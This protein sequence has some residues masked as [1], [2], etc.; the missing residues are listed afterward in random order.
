LRFWDASAIVPLLVEEPAHP[1]VH[2][3]LADDTSM[4]VWWASPVECVSAL[5]RRNRE[6]SLEESALRLALERLRVLS[7]AWHEILPT[8]TV[9]SQAERMLRV[10]PLRAA[11]AL[12]LAA[13]LV[14]AEQQPSDL[15][16]LCLDDRLSAAAS[17]EGF[18]LTA[19]R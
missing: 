9:R 7:R 4:L 3:A 12:Q 2:Q 13:A 6:G 10:H 18:R 11:D 19:P 17:R 14:A 8:Q 1:A 5:S 16:F 15:E